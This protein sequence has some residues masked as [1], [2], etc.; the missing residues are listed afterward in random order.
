[1]AEKEHREELRE[2][3]MRYRKLEDKTTD[4]LATRLLKE[5]LSELEADLNK[6]A[7]Q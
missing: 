7:K 2:K 4:P 5:I 3:I 6:G 1:M